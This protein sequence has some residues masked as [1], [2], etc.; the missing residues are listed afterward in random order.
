MRFP[1]RVDQGLM[2]KDRVAVSSGR[3]EKLKKKEKRDGNGIRAKPE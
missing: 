3:Q 2:G 1:G